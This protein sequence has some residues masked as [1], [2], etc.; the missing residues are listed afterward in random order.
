MI[1]PGLARYF[2]ALLEHA[3]VVM[4]KRSIG[5]TSLK[6]SISCHMW[7]PAACKG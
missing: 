7:V 1:S 3:G 2:F 5:L 4:D 6:S